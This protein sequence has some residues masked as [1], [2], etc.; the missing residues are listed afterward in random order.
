MLWLYRGALGFESHVKRLTYPS[1]GFLS[2]KRQPKSRNQC[3][4]L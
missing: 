4:L 2:C 1:L 3:V